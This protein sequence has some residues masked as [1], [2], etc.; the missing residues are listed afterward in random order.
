MIEGSGVNPE[1]ARSLAGVAPGTPEMKRAWDE[2]NAEKPGEAVL[3][4]EASAPFIAAEGAMAMDSAMT[5]QAEVNSQAEVLQAQL[6]KEH[7]NEQAKK[8]AEA[9]YEGE[10]KAA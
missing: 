6:E 1:L 2:A 7:E 4:E 10:K 8:Q 3:D 5:K 9:A